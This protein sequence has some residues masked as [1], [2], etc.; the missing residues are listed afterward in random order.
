MDGVQGCIIRG[1]GVVLKCRVCDGCVGKY[2]RRGSNG[3]VLRRRIKWMGC[4]A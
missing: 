2:K 1:V 3:M 4:R